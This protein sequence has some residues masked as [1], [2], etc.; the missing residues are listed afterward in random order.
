MKIL[1]I[2]K[3]T[4]D[5]GTYLVANIKIKTCKWEVLVW[6]KSQLLK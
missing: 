5:G 3:H 1:I 6:C 4:S 2:G